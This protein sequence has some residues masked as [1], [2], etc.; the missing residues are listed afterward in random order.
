L[1]QK[2]LSQ[3]L[4]FKKK[5]AKNC[6]NCLWHEKAFQIFLTFIIWTTV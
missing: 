4:L 2:I 5:I 6:H 3:I 1:K